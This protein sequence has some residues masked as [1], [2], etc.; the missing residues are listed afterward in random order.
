MD[1]DKLR[2]GTAGIPIRTKGDTLQ[3]IKEVRKLN[4]DCFELEFVRG[5]NIKEEKTP[6][7]KK[8]AKEN[9]VILS[10]HSPYWVNLNS[11]D[12]KKYH[13]SISYIVNSAKISSL[14]GAYSVTFHA[15]YYQKQSLNLVY[16]K[17]KSG[18]KEIVKQVRE[19]DKSLW[20][21]PEVSGKPSQFG[22]VEELIKLSQDIEQVMPCIDFSHNFSRSIGKAN[23]LEDFKDVLNKIK[24]NLGK[25]YLEG[26]HIHISGIEYGEK[27]EKHH[28]I[29]EESKFNY[30][31]LLKVLK[32]FK[33]KGIVICESPNI[34]EDALLM[35]NYFEKV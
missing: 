24:D 32:E 31:D 35:K 25:E 10:C 6:E 22:S 3:G 28:L 21:S 34:E 27:G 29:L 4:L 19:F 1:F 30:K 5:I 9:D 26:M 8:V 14:C 13:A 16:E 18:I 2:F 20:I 7:I 23:K 11:E 17:I 15:G 33:V 12:K